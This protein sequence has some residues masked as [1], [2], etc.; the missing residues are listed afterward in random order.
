MRDRPGGKKVEEEEEEE[1]VEDK[2]GNNGR[3]GWVC[4]WVE[5]LNMPLWSMKKRK[6]VSR[7]R[8]I[9]MGGLSDY[10]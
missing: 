8:V 10:M 5:V 3:G 9:E 7:E 6:E 1:R 4:G 2:K